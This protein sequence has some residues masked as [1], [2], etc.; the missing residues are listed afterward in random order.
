MEPG[1]KNMLVHRLVHPEFVPDEAEV[2]DYSGDL[3]LKD[4]LI[5]WATSDKQSFDTIESFGIGMDV[6]LRNRLHLL[7]YEDLYTGSAIWALRSSDL[8]YAFVQAYGPLRE[9]IIVP[10]YSQNWAKTAQE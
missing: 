10:R 5:E 7:P 8:C 2:P 6:L 1:E 9:D 4:S 3:N